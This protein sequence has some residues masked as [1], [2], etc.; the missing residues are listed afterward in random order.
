MRRPVLSRPDDR[1]VRILKGIEAAP[2]AP[3][4]SPPVVSG[5]GTPDGLKPN[6]TVLKGID[7]APVAKD[8]SPPVMSGSGLPT[9]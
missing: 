3:D 9:G 6:A 2:V 8:F 1:I 5:S 7:A 4:F